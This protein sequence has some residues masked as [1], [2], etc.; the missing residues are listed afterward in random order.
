MRWLQTLCVVLLL[1]LAGCPVNE[2]D[3]DGTAPARLSRPG[4]AAS[5]SQ[6]E[7]VAAEYPAAA[8]E[9]VTG[10]LMTPAQ[11]GYAALGPAWLALSRLKCLAAS[12]SAAGI[13]SALALNLEEAGTE[14]LPLL[15]AAWL[16]VEPEQAAEFLAGQL[17]DGKYEYFDSF[18]HHPDA[19]VTALAGL[20]CA[21]LN[22]REAVRCLMLVRRW[23]RAGDLA[24][25]LKVL[26]EHEAESVRLLSIGMLISCGEATEEQVEEL[27]GAV[28]DYQ[29]FSNVAEG[30]KLSGDPEMAGAL[31]PV[32][33]QMEAGDVDPES[34]QHQVSLAAYALTGLPG[35]QAE[36]M[37]DR[38]LGAVDPLV[39]WQARLGKLLQGA[40]D[41]WDKAVEESGITDQDLWIAL[42][43]EDIADPALVPTLALAARSDEPRLRSMAALQLN[44]YAA[45]A[46]NQRVHTLVEKLTADE[47]EN[48]RSAAWFC[49]GTL[50]TA[51]LLPAA[52]TDIADENQPQQVRLGAA[53]YAL[54]L[55]EVP[56]T[57]GE[58]E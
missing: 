51:G 36:L 52:S 48:V 47:D 44:R 20:D 31:V 38:L 46:S 41:T 17:A 1:A 27:R 3:G 53:F 24:D 50:G 7:Q 32:A 22:E 28:A 4:D 12:D 40:P 15:C 9:Y 5:V 11:D 43:A 13:R 55:A 49:A 19:G 29:R 21:G 34:R 37:R 14:P 8:V 45:I 35:S 16:A 39:R 30:I 25:Q 10:C 57:G 56:E 54:R 23:E 2:P 26:A 42:Q 58:A 18:W 33:A 6:V